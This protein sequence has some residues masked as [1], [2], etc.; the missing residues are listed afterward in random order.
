MQPEHPVYIISRGR[1]DTRLTA[2]WLDHVG[3]PFLM[4]VE[5]EE[6]PRYVDAVGQG[7]LL[8]LPERY[9]RNYDT[10]VRTDGVEH[11][12]PGPARNFVWDHARQARAKFHWLLDDNIRSLMYMHQGVK[13]RAGDGAPFRIM[14]E[15]MTR[16]ENLAMLCP[17]HNIYAIP[18]RRY[19]HLTLNVMVYC[20][21]LI[22]TSL[23]HVFRGRY[24][25]DTDMSLQVL[26][27]GWCTAV[28]NC[29][30]QQKAPTKRIGGGN[31]DTIYAGDDNGWRQ[32]RGTYLLN[33]D[34]LT[35]RKRPRGWTTDINY[36]MLRLPRLRRDPAQVDRPPLALDFHEVALADNESW[37]Q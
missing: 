29:I 10:V 8:I 27:D 18:G 17:R 14:E 11:L 34:V 23:G 25:E 35:M 5:R 33:P 9:K 7:R 1:W 2:K 3:V 12:G 4:V 30:L 16:W 28:L 15:F 22:R 13:R 21:I 36:N 31:T 6:W 24:G 32:A 19:D 20:C 26:R 37:K